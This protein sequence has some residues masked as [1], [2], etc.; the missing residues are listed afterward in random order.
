M[1]IYFFISLYS[2][3][4]F[5]NSMRHDETFRDVSCSPVYSV[6]H[7]LCTTECTSVAFYPMSLNCCLH[8]A[9]QVFLHFYQVFYVR[10]NNKFG[11]QHRHNT[12]LGLFSHRCSS[13][14]LCCPLQLE[15]Q[16]HLHNTHSFI[17]QPRQG[18][19]HFEITLLILLYSNSQ[20]AV[21][22]RSLPEVILHHK[23]IPLQNKSI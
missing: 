7:L 9:L 4:L 12:D 11:M 18:F 8:C 1:L 5:S 22:L 13:V 3:C 10:C 15:L 16:Q 20:E 19:I 21:V 23:N 2:L 14:S 17:H 6:L